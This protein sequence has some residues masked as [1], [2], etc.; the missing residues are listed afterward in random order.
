[1]KISRVILLALILIFTGIII[2]LKPKMQKQVRL[3]NPDFQVEE[4]VAWNG[5]YS[6]VSNQLLKTIK[7]P[8]DKISNV[9]NIYVKFEVDRDGNIDSITTRTKPADSYAVADKYIIPA[10]KSL[11]GKSLLAFPPKSKR[12][13]VTYATNIVPSEKTV[14]TTPSD[15][16]SY[17]K[18][19]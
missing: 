11:Q 4:T 3:E 18:V 1:M 2:T 8:A 17:E 6:N 7:L 19:K 13:T 14:F 10:I 15:F 16:Q 5:W 12:K 9:T